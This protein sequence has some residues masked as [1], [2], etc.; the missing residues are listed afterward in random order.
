MQ[1][2]DNLR[3]K[4]GDDKLLHF[5]GG[6]WFLSAFTPFSWIGLLI[7]AVILFSVSFIKEFFDDEFDWK[8]ILA[9]GLGASVSTL[10]Y[11]IIFLFI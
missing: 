11:L 6:G 1:W 8:D 4:I 9:T 10:I 3:A 5:F 2:V 7:G